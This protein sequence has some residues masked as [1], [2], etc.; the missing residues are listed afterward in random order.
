MLVLSRWLKTR[1]HHLDPPSNTSQAVS[2]SDHGGKHHSPNVGPIGEQQHLK[3]G[4]RE[5]AFSA[6]VRLRR[7]FF[8]EG[9]HASTIMVDTLRGQ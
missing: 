6:A 4:G 9:L 2:D 3:I 8:W 7:Y 5:E 1:F